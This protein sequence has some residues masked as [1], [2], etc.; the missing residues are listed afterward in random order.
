M[1][2]CAGA[3]EDSLKAQRCADY[4]D[5]IRYAVP[6]IVEAFFD[7]FDPWQQFEQQDP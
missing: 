3:R 2:R 5:G 6:G 1:R 4:A 7:A